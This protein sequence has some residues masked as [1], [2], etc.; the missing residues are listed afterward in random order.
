MSSPHSSYVHTLDPRTKLLQFG[1]VLIALFS[2]PPFGTGLLMIWAIA[3]W[4]AAGLWRQ[5]APIPRSVL[6]LAAI[7][8]ITHAW[9]GPGPYL[10]IAGLQFSSPGLARGAL[11]AAR[12]VV[13]ATAA[14]VL[15]LTTTPLELSRAIQWLLYPLR[16][17][18]VAVP[19]L[20]MLLA[21]STRFLPEIQAD[22]RR[23]VALRRL[24]HQGGSDL[25][26]V[27]RLRFSGLQQAG[28]EVLVP[29]LRLSL[30]RAG[31]LGDAL[32]LRGYA[33]GRQPLLPR[34]TPGSRELAAWIVTAVFLVT[35]WLL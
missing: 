22:A 10:Q 3:A 1:A 7:T 17:M 20:P 6:V 4:L 29:L 27:A 8:V 30:R 13:M 12:L 15:T 19:D 32:A 5:T 24:R 25:P 14:R 21:V 35:A 18:S 9:W 26:G 28:S 11:L 31:K 23:L 16:K 34:Y 33:P 2:T